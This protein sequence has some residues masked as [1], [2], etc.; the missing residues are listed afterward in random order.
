MDG[1]GTSYYRAHGV[2]AQLAKKIDLNIIKYVQRMGGWQWSDFLYADI[3]F[4]QRPGTVEH[5]KLCEYAK[6]LNRKIWVDYDD[7]FFVM[8]PENRMFDAVDKECKKRMIDII[9]M[10]DVVTVSTKALYDQ[11]VSLGATHCEIIPNALNTDVSPPVK[12]Y[13]SK[14]PAIPPNP[15]RQA[16]VWRGS[17]THWMD[18]FDY[19]E[20]LPAAMEARQDV[21]WFFMAWRPSYL[22]RF[23]LKYIYV[24]PEDMIGY[25][26]KL[27]LLRP[28][29]VHVP[30]TPNH[31]N[32]SKSNIAWIEA[33]AAG[34]V[35]VA[36]DWSEWQR[37]GV[38]TYDTKEKYR[39]ILIGANDLPLADK[40]QESMDY[41]HENLILSKVNEKRAD[42]I[43]RLMSS[44]V[45][46]PI[47]QS[48]IE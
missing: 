30:L 46:L 16:Y 43:E 48:M 13:N 44:N 12:S 19:L 35:C 29:V 24:K 27:K 9:R 22:D 45:Q 1:D 10:A 20:Q 7:N 17:D 31:F 42:V 25:F 2:F 26:A 39:D 38:L 15:A 33:T 21:D 5:F 47:P 6:D 14:R 11:M 37:P 40:W 4:L 36:P 32:L 23:G 28:E 3:V 18:V 41:I 34:A 8:P